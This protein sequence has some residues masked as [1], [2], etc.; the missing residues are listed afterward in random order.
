MIYYIYLHIRLVTEAKFVLRER[1]KCEREERGMKREESEGK[2][3]RE[4]REIERIERV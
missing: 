2:R 1:E 4:R 3:V